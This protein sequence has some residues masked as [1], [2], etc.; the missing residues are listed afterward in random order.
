MK[1]LFLLF[2]FLTFSAEAQTKKS[3]NSLKAGT[4][5]GYWGYNRSA[6]TKSNLHVVGPG[7]DLTLKGAK[8]Y[9]NPY[10]VGL[11]YFSPSKITI[12]QFNGRL[13]YMIKNSIGISLGTEHMKYLFADHNKVKL[14]GFVNPGV[15]TV[16]S[17][18][19]D[20]QE[21]IT[22]RRHFHYE[23]SNG[24]NYIN[25]QM[26]KFKNL[27]T[28][29]NN[30][31]FKATAQFGVGTGIL[32]VYND[33]KFAGSYDVSNPSVSG[34]GI[35][36]HGAVRLEFWNHFFLQADLQTGWNL[37][38]HVRLKRNDRNWYA[39]QNYFYGMAGTYVGFLFYLK[40]GKNGCDTCPKW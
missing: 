23:N 40:G 1:L 22:D 14:N 33:F 12:P 30:N 18:N 10:P 17:G 4:L 27:Y 28:P 11:S 31:W 37:Q 25:V 5:Y 34:W 32:F 7:F 20:N 9:D 36:A 35:S 16:W 15:D 38:T 19:Y 24:L 26:T 21:V 13:G 39:K 29:R 3:K 2:L 8:A 6:Y